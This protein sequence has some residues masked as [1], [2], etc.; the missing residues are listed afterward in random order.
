[1]QA[2]RDIPHRLENMK[3]SFNETVSSQLA[4]PQGTSSSSTSP[5]KSSSGTTA[6]SMNGAGTIMTDSSKASSV[7]AP[8]SSQVLSTLQST[9]L[10]KTSSARP[11]TTSSTALLSEPS[12]A[13][14]PRSAPLRWMHTLPNGHRELSHAGIGA[15]VVGCMSLGLALCL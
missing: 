1:M 8:Y 13:A 11:T 3:G 5:A 2:D 12:N 7:T 15:V 6:S 4:R 14:S 10:S 9:A